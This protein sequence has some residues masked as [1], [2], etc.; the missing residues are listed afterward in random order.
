M[1]AWVFVA[2]VGNAERDAFDFSIAAVDEEALFLDQ[3]W[4]LATSMS[5]PPALAPLL[6]QV[7]VSDSKPGSG[8]GLKPW[9]APHS[10]VICASLR[11]RA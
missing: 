4:S 3:I 11:C 2:H 10:R 6:K 9:R 8:K 7:S 5:R 1:V